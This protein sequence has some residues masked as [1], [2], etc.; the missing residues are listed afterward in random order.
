MLGRRPRLERRGLLPKTLLYQEL[1][2]N[3]SPAGWERLTRPIPRAMR[4]REVRKTKL[5]C[6]YLKNKCIAHAAF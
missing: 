5:G 3:R 6:Y 4:F 1:L 2:T